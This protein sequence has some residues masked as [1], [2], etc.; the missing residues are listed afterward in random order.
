MPTTMVYS[1]FPAG[2]GSAGSSD[3]TRRI[4][5]RLDPSLALPLSREGI[6]CRHRGPDDDF[7][8]LRYQVWYPSQ[9]CALRTR[10]KTCTGCLNCDQGRFNLKRHERELARSRVFRTVAL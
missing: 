2:S 6:A 10:Y 7:F 9:D 4:V 3:G 1:C 5:S 8:C